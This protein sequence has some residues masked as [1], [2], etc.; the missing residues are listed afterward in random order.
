MHRT[1]NEDCEKA[2]TLAQQ[3][4][5]LDRF[6]LQF[7][8]Q[9]PHQALN[10]EVPAQRYVRSP[11]R[12]PTRERDPSYADD[13]LIERVGL[14]GALRFQGNASLISVLLARQLPG[15]RRVDTRVWKL[16]FGPVYLGYLDLKGF[17]PDRPWRPKSATR[18]VTDV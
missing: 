9:R 5:C 15:L 13:M 6:R 2:A 8:T 16:F 17:H 14:D 11:R 7:N 10:H 12:F 1:L 4:A 3:Q 18:R